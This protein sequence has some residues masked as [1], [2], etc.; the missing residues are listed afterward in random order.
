[1]CGVM[2]VAIAGIG[3]DFRSSEELIQDPFPRTVDCEMFSLEGKRNRGDIAFNWSS[4]ERLRNEKREFL[5]FP[6][7]RSFMMSYAHS[8]SQLIRVD[9]EYRLGSYKVYQHRSCLL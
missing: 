1:M 9:T 7:G 6:F 3:T 2:H 4:S 5:F 8:T